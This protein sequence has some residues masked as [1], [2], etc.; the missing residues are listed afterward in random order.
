M[1]PSDPTSYPRRVLVC[2]IGLAPQVLTETLYSLA[3]QAWPPWIPTEI[4]VVTTAAGARTLR[5][6]LL[7]DGETPYKELLRDYLPGSPIAFDDTAAHLHEITRD[8]VVLEDIEDPEGSSA[9]ADTILGVVARLVADGNCAIHASI[10][11]GRKTMGFYLGYAMSLLGR[12]QDRLSHV[13]V[14]KPFEDHREFFFP[15]KQPRDLQLKDGKTV[16]TSV[17]TVTLAPIRVVMFAEGLREK[18]IEQGLGFDALVQQA[19]SDLVPQAVRIT[20]AGHMITVGEDSGMAS[21]MLEPAE[22]ALYL[23]LAQRR[24]DRLHQPE[25]IAPGMVRVH[26]SP[27]RNLGID[28]AALRSAHLRVGIAYKP[29]PIDPDWFK[30]KVS[31]INKALRKAFVPSVA[32]RLVVIGPGDRGARDGQY[33]LLNLESHLIR[34]G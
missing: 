22:M 33:G 4:H 21:A 5:K 6:S 16:S 19:E 28:E 26:K 27:E 23:Y 1:N 8:D 24:R 14:S 2:V 32:H 9:A 18:I 17:A 13:L 29:F 25:L 10:A 31:A 11:G 12:P 30:P 20:P 34:I 3:I 15:P 7:V